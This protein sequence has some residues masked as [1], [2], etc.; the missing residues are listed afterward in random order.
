MGLEKA[1]NLSFLVRADAIKLFNCMVQE[2]GGLPLHLTKPLGGLPPEDWQEVK[3][4]C[5]IYPETADAVWAQQ[6]EESKAMAATT[7]SV[8]I[9]GIA[10]GATWGSAGAAKPG[11]FSSMFSL[12]GLNAYRSAASGGAR[13]SPYEPL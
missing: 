9:G 5:D 13:S 6:A 3:D 7:R 1:G 8:G 10:T 12:G 11:T 2:G 4:A